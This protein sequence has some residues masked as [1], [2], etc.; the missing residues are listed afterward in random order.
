MVQRAR[1]YGMK[2]LVRLASLPTS[3][4]APRFSA[5]VNA[6]LKRDS[7]ITEGD[8]RGMIE[9]AKALLA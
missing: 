9:F 1:T 3:A 4:D 8:F 6:A 7:G 5:I 2:V